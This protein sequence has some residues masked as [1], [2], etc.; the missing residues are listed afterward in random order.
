MHLIKNNISFMYERINTYLNKYNTFL[1]LSYSFPKREIMLY[2]QYKI[3]NWLK[4]LAHKSY[5]G[6]WSKR[7]IAK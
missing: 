4:C 1:I 7:I 2:N 3:K 6:K 5:K